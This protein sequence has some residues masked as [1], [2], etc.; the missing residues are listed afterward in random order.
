MEQNSS[1]RF[2][3]IFSKVF[4]DAMFNMLKLIICAWDLREKCF[5]NVKFIKRDFRVA[6][7]KGTREWHVKPSAALNL[8]GM[9]CFEHGNCVNF[10]TEILKKDILKKKLS[11]IPW[12]NIFCA[13]GD[14][15][16]VTIRFYHR[17]RSCNEPSEIIRNKSCENKL[18]RN[19]NVMLCIIYVIQFSC[20]LFDIL[21]DAHCL[22]ITKCDIESQ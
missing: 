3:I 16:T 22:L 7:N 4:L 9:F 20:L 13:L 12:N 11:L 8:L 15:F 5:L 6:H 14:G 18:E 10:V 19:K 2:D 1:F 21:N 17:I